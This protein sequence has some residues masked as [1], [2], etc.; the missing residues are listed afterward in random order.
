VQRNRCHYPKVIEPTFRQN[1]SIH[2]FDEKTACTGTNVAGYGGTAEAIRSRQTQEPTMQQ[3]STMGA[4][5]FCR[6]FASSSTRG[7]ESFAYYGSTPWIDSTKKI[8][9]K[10]S[11]END[12]SVVFSAKRQ[13]RR[14]LRK[15]EENAGYLFILA[16]FLLTTFSNV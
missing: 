7:A 14:F 3:S 2:D 1:R 15:G 8:R 12:I 13:H 9:R 5:V 4:S 11:S 6:F 10:T 16:I